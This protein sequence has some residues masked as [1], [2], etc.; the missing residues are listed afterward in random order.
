VCFVLGRFS[1]RVLARS[2]S[3]DCARNES[4]RVA[5]KIHR[6]S[7]MPSIC[8]VGQSPGLRLNARGAIAASSTWADRTEVWL[9]SMVPRTNSI[10]LPPYAKR[11][12]RPSHS[13]S[14]LA[15]AVKWR[16]SVRARVVNRP[17]PGCADLL[18]MRPIKRLCL[19]SWSALLE[20]PSTRPAG[21]TSI[22]SSRTFDSHSLQKTTRQKECH[23]IRL[24]AWLCCESACCRLSLA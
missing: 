17:L 21:K 19:A 9:G 4:R 11:D 24:L 13:P 18:L 16:W 20:H 23:C 2:C 1:H 22:C 15:I 3:E 12:L 6:L 7:I 10:L 5:V 8:R 14:S